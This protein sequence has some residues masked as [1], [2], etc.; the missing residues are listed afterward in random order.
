V[1]AGEC[2]AVS[3]LAQIGDHVGADFELG[4]VR[5]G[6]AMCWALDETV[7]GPKCS[8]GSMD[9]YRQRDCSGELNF[10]DYDLSR[11]LLTF[12]ELVRL[13]PIGMDIDTQPRSLLGVH[14]PEDGVK[15]ELPSTM[16]HSTLPTVTETSESPNRARPVRLARS[17]PL[18]VTSTVSNLMVVAQSRWY[19]SASHAS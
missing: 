15:R 10:L 3:S 19:I 14:V 7:L 18:A 2:D 16:G 6:V 11:I 13:M 5:L 17:G 12:E 1:R 8:I 4:L 9:V